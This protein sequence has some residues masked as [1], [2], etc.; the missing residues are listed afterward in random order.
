MLRISV[1][2]D[3]TLSSARNQ[4]EPQLM[5]RMFGLL[6]NRPDL[7]G[8]LLRANASALQERAEPGRPMGWGVGF[9]QAGEVLLQRRPSDVRPVVDVTEGL[10]TIRTDALIA[11]VRRPHIGSLRT[12]NTQPFRY[13]SWLFAQT[14]TVNGFERLGERLLASQPKFLRRNVRGETDAELCFYLFLSFLHD[15]GHL[16]AQRV[17]PAR[18]SEALRASVA[19]VDRLS[20][21]EGHEQNA[22][23]MMVCNGEY[24]LALHRSGELAYQEVLGRRGVEE[25]LGSDSREAPIANIEQTRYTLIAAGIGAL[26]SGW[27]S[28]PGRVI[29]SVTREASPHIET[30]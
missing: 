9:F 22:G 12:E 14:G 7:A 23:D 5:A 30:L 19:L 18:V 29:V 10:T 2:V 24:L 13:R 15:A 25:L 8:R 16:D 28:V 3:G 6:G 21:E 17:E 4:P 26:P 11:H 1:R 20:A 27:T